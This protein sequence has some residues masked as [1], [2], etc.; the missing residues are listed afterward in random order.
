MTEP[1]GN[2]APERI[3]SLLASG[4]ELVCALGLGERL[5]GRSHECDHP[6]WVKRLPVVS[7]PTFPIDGTSREIDEHVRTRLRAGEPLY[8]IDEALLA[9]LRPDVVITQ[10]HCEVCAVSPGDLAHGGLASLDRRPV[11]ALGSGTLA[12]IVDGFLEVSK[13]L[14]REPEGHALVT[15]LRDRMA[16]VVE[17]TRA[18]PRRRVACLEWLDP[19]F[20]MGN[21]GP[22]LVE[23]AGGENL[24]GT[25]GAHST[26]ATWDTVR[27][28]DP[29]VLVIAPCGF[30]IAR[31]LR[32]MPRFADQPG[33]SEMR[34]AKEGRVFVAD[35]N[36]YFNRSGP[37][38]FETVEILAEILHP[39][40]FPPG[41][42]RSAWVR[43]GE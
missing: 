29:D 1:I 30:D 12:G 6:E 43:W 15:S 19:I 4:T 39:E 2:Q 11:V 38:A 28:T 31:T 34:A 5:V 23:A 42:Q 27:D 17:R 10:T 41:H 36:L 20:V 33:F 13:V 8:R 21:W 9:S 24:L 26:A 40:A 18:L 14:G 7:H 25:V 32:E 16:R 35:G 3:V 37:T 22:E